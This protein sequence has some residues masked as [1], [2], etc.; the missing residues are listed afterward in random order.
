MS[1]ESITYAPTIESDGWGKINVSCQ[2]ECVTF[3]VPCGLQMAASIVMD[4]SDF[5]KAVEIVT[6]YRKMREIA[7]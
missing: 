1:N 7:G 2:G 5:D 3:S 6:Q 4:L